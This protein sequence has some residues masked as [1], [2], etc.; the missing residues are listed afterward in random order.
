M[1]GFSSGNFRKMLD[2]INQQAM[3]QA[4]PPQ[5]GLTLGQL[6]S[7]PQGTGGML[8]R[9]AEQFRNAEGMPSTGMS[10]PRQLTQ[11][12]AMALTSM[13]RQQ[14]GPV[15]ERPQ[16]LGLGMRAPMMPLP[17][18]PAPQ[19]PSS[20]E[21]MRLI[22]EM[23]QPAQVNNSTMRMGI[24]TPGFEFG[25]SPQQMAPNA[26]G[27]ALGGLMAKYGGGMC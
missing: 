18:M 19:G 11:E 17:A 27:M 1:F 13:P 2:R 22:Q 8:S 9:F 23:R 24:A 21:M 3:P 20:D 10:A 15:M 16:G 25:K 7:G 26:Q 5:G 4:L 14:M 6:M 12:E